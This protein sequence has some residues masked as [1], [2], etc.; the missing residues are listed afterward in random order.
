MSITI[1]ADSLPGIPW[2][3]RPA[4]SSSPVWR[5]SANPIIGRNPA[6]GAARVFN[7]A[8][9]PFEGAYVGVFRCDLTAGNF[10]LRLG[11]S[12]N[13]VDWEI[14]NE[15]L[16]IGDSVATGYD[17]RVIKIDDVY[18]VNW[19]TYISGGPT[20]G[21]A[22]TTDFRHF[23]RLDEPFLPCNRNGVLFP[24]RIRG[25]YAMLSRPSDRGHTPFGDIYYSESP[26][27]CFWGKHR[28][29][30][31]SGSGGGWERTKVGPGPFPI[32]T[33]EGWLMIYHGVVSPCNGYVYSMGAALLD[34]DEPHRV[35]ARCRDYLLTPE[36]PYEEIGFVPNVI[37]PCATLCDGG[38]GRLAIYYGAADSYVAIAFGT[39]EEIVTYV[40]ENAR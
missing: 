28:F 10:H 24:R 36:T 25:N 31:G 27:L 11:R 19:C 21:M 33:S 4:G 38:T 23:E 17:P 35:I 6:R 3:E 30:F 40:K 9:V 39:V 15:G 32:E 7:S 26:D 12:R 1:V 34:L 13:A 37:F 2:E 22:R 16:V 20:I 14:E 8:V 5:Y 29:V 18:Y